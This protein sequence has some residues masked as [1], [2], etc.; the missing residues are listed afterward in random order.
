MNN[1]YS[2]TMAEN[3]SRLI[4]AQEVQE[5]HLSMS[6]S[7]GSDE[8][9]KEQESVKE[10]RSPGLGKENVKT[11]VH[12]IKDSGFD[13]TNVDDSFHEAEDYVA[14]VMGS[15]AIVAVLN[16]PSSTLASGRKRHLSMPTVSGT[17]LKKL[18]SDINCNDLDQS[19]NKTDS[20]SDSEN[21][22]TQSKSE[23]VGKR[24]IIRARRN[25]M[26][27]KQPDGKAQNKMN[28]KTISKSGK[29]TEDESKMK[30][31]R[32]SANKSGN[33]SKS[34]KKQEKVNKW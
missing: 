34:K 17:D 15:Q 1:L 5:T 31:S 19:G 29:E 4:S 11:I 12:S 6:S 27:E 16:T 33:G 14:S 13:N 25:L 22:N 9:T 7:P 3:S 30:N 24:T 18:R 8:N 21:D 2:D 10:C 23:T 20:D 26:S 32:T 28:S